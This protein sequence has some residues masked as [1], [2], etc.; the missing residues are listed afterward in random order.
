MCRNIKRLRQQDSLP[1]DEELHLAALQFVRKVSGFRIPSRRNAA[2]FD[3]AVVEIAGTTQKLLE[4][5]VA[6]SAPARSKTL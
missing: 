4:Q 5:L 1:S 2:A 6:H 3:H